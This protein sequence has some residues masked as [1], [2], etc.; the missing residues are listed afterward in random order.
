MTDN[1]KAATFIGWHEGEICNGRHYGQVECPKSH[2]GR[3][4]D[5]EHNVPA[6]DMSDPRNYM[7]ALADIVE[8]LNWTST[9]NK[10]VYFTLLGHKPNPVIT[11][12]AAI[13]DSEHVSVHA[14]VKNKDAD[15]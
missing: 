15:S 13:Y 10:A 6:P 12:L 2:Y 8:P 7:K 14:C 3:H 4:Q 5:A 9:F 11:A 1:E